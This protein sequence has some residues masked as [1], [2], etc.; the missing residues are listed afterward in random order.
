MD[1]IFGTAKAASERK[2]LSRNWTLP[3]ACLTD[4]DVE[5]IL[6]SNGVYNVLDKNPKLPLCTLKRGNPLKN[7]KVMESLNP[8][9]AEAESEREKKR[10]ALTKSLE[11]KKKKLEGLVNKRKADL[12]KEIKTMD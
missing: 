4:T 3:K 11:G 12:L 7:K 6:S 9:L 5:K 1:K 8:A 10:A 2:Y